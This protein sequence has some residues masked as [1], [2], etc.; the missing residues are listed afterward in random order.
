MGG[1]AIGI[2][3]YPLI[4]TSWLCSVCS[5]SLCSDSLGPITDHS[6]LLLELRACPLTLVSAFPD[7]RQ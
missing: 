4:L 7:T 6:T 1:Y 2:C 3:S 5:E